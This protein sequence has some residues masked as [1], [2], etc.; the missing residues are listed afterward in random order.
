MSKSTKNKKKELPTCIGGLKAKDQVHSTYLSWQ[1][2][3]GDVKLLCWNCADKL[4]K[5]TLVNESSAITV[6]DDKGIQDSAT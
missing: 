5:E 4:H 6:T 3:E 1:N 2:I